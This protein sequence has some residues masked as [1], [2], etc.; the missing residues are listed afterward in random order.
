MSRIHKFIAHAM[1][2]AALSGFLLVVLLAI[3]H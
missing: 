3:G 1:G 2:L